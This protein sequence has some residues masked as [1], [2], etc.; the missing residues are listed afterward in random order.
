MLKTANEA[1]KNA[2]QDLRN[3][4]RILEE[5]IENYKNQDST[6]LQGNNNIFSNFE[7]NLK[8]FIISN[9]KLAKETINKN[10]DI[11]DKII[12]IQS[13]NQNFLKKNKKLWDE[14]S[15]IAEKIEK[16][17]RKK[18]EIKIT[19]ED[20]EK[21]ISLL[22]DEKHNLNNEIEILKIDLLKLKNNENN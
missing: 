7:E 11:V 20:N 2:N 16:E 15:K 19:N 5:E 9:K 12:N 3:Q 21:K 22:N 4:N 13:E 10:L 18:A 6:I 1:F 17:N 8:N 14:H